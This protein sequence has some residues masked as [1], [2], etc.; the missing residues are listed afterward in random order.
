VAR[1]VL[2]NG[3]TFHHAMAGEYV[4]RH[5]C[6]FIPL[7]SG[8]FAM[9]DEGLVVQLVPRQPVLT[10]ASE[11][12]SPAQC[13]LTAALN[14]VSEETEGWGYECPQVVTLLGAMGLPATAVKAGAHWR[15]AGIAIVAATHGHQS[16]LLSRRDA[17]VSASKPIRWT[18]QRPAD[19]IADFAA[20]EG[21]GIDTPMGKADAP[22]RQ[23]VDF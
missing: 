13:A 15:T 14:G 20:G 23:R 7:T 4:S 2:P 8:R 3:L 9:I 18:W 12:R 5:A 6:R 21:W 1:P 11:S 10:S 19:G 16:N 22:R 17:A